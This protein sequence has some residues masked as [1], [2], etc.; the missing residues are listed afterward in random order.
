MNYFFLFFGLFFSS[1]AFTQPIVYVTPSGAGTSSGDSW[2]NALSGTQLPARV[3]TASAGTQFWIAAGTY[4]V[5]SS[6]SFGGFV[7]QDGLKVYGGFSGKETKLE[8]RIFGLNETI[9]FGANDNTNS[10]IHIILGRGTQ[11]IVIDGIT[12]HGGQNTSSGAGIDASM[13]FSKSTLL[14]SNCR[15]IDNKSSTCGALSILASDS[16]SCKLTIRNCYFSGNSGVNAG[17][18]GLF[19]SSFSASME[20]L[21]ENCVFSEN[22][23]VGLYSYSGPGAIESVGNYSSTTSLKIV[24]CKFLNNTALRLGGAISVNKMNCEIENSIFTNNSVTDSYGEGGVLYARFSKFVFKNCLFKNNNAAYGGVVHNEGYSNL[25]TSQF[26]LNC[27]FVSNSALKS[28]GVFHNGDFQGLS[29]FNPNTIYLKNCLVWGNTAPNDP[30]YKPQTWNSPS[31]N[32]MKSTLVT[33]YSLIQDNYPGIGNLDT[34]PLFINP[35]NGDFRLK[36]NSP[37][38]NAGDPNI[39]NLPATDLAGQPRVQGGQVDIGAYEF[40]SC[41]DGSCLPFIIRRVR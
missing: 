28:G 7:I 32:Q 37:A 27:N 33:T 12:I 35:A 34:D 1:S 40:F 14:I 19:A 41:P 11:N 10:I 15:F 21:L 17:A 18:F 22:S 3:V 2:A 4:K 25:P 31:G 29:D 20:S 26:F 24:D 5:Y 36:P 9:F 8:E 30:V 38:I 13:I 23:G 6:G 16:T 39:T